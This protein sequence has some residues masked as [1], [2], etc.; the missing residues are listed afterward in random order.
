VSEPSWTTL[1][2]LASARHCMV[3]SRGLV[4]PWSNRWCLDWWIGADDRWHFPSPDEA[5]RQRLVSL[6][7]VVETAMRVPGGDAVQ[8]AYAIRGAGRSDELLVIEVE[9]RSPA[10]FAVAFALRRSG[11]GDPGAMELIDLDERTVMVDGRPGLYLPR[12][13]GRSAVGG[14][15]LASMVASGQAS[16]QFAP[17]GPDPSGEGQAAF[18]FP[19]AHTATIRVAVPLVA[20]VGGRRGGSGSRGLPP[21]PSMPSAADA[22]RAWEAQTRR[23]LRAELPPSRLA[24]AVEANRRFLL[25]APSGDG[26]G[27]LL[28]GRGLVDSASLA[29]ALDRWGF[30]REAAEIL[31]SYPRLQRLDGQFRRPRPSTIDEPAANGAVLWAIGEHHRLSGD[32]AGLRPLVETIAAGARWIERERHKRRRHRDP[33]YRGLLAPRRGP[34][35]YADSLWSLRGLLD[36][37]ELLQAAGEEDAA[38]TAASWAAGFRS[39]L[40]ASL[41]TAVEVA[42]S[43]AETLV[44]CSPLGLYAPSHP[45]M[46]AAADAVRARLS[47]ADVESTRLAL[48]LGGTELLAGDQ[49]VLERLARVVESATDTLIWPGSRPGQDLGMTVEFCTFARQLLVHE[50]PG[51]LALCRVV[52]EGWWGQPL[53]VHDAPTAAG[54]LSFAL[55]W[56]GERPALLWELKTHHDGPV[57]L[58]APGFDPRWSS[59]EASGEALLDPVGEA[60]R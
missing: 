1:G 11:G 34:F 51:G 50:V 28:G 42:S 37:A 36:A 29:V 23:G 21:P 46:A 27:G 24:D 13:P 33:A 41:A 52:P 60:G 32:G 19:L 54:L 30:H 8:R 2:N 48:L 35:L 22:A 17:L 59:E 4:R 58:S 39:H 12:R 15:G 10:P 49:R 44:G 53:E 20:E 3:D 31:D 9:N 25:L 5:I 38:V 57:R 16:E 55:R 7:P 26:Q 14:T 18:I 6:T 47:G 43:S 40:D 56:H 45:A